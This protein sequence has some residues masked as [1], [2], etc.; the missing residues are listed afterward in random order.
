MH[1]AAKYGKIKTAIFASENIQMV[2]RV[3][4]MNLADIE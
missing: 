1:M 3:G 2:L 4:G